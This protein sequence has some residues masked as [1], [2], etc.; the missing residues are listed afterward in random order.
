MA[1]RASTREI[2]ASW[3]KSVVNTPGCAAFHTVSMLWMWIWICPLNLL[4]ISLDRFS[5]LSGIPF[6]FLLAGWSTSCLRRC[7]NDTNSSATIHIQMEKLF[8][9]VPQWLLSALLSFLSL[10]QMGSLAVFI[11]CQQ[12]NTSPQT[13]GEVRISV[14]Y[15]WPWWV[16]GLIQNAFHLHSFSFL[17]TVTVLSDFDTHKQ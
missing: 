3:M 6:S 13:G 16:F 11:Q 9:G 1:L 14:D 8:L 17:H 15:R 2:N 5:N 10:T 12:H 7:L 4:T